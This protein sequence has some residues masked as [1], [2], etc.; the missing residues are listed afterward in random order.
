MEGKE[1]EEIPRNK[2][3]NKAIGSMNAETAVK[4]RKLH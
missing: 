1:H 4:R 2:F 3:V